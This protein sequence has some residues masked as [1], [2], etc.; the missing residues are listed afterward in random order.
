MVREHATN[1]SQHLQENDWAL[2]HVAAVHARARPDSHMRAPAQADTHWETMV[3][4]A[5]VHSKQ[6]W[7]ALNAWS[8]WK[9]RYWGLS[10]GLSVTFLVFVVLQVW[11]QGCFGRAVRAT[12]ERV[13]AQRTLAVERLVRQ[14]EPFSWVVTAFLRWHGQGDGNA[15][16][17]T[18][19]TKLGWLAELRQAVER[20]REAEALPADPFD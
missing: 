20:L 17:G 2:A 16:R 8:R 9:R 12:T 10:G 3:S 7:L 19:E 18:T 11:N 13:C 6:S 15:T 14:G 1:K 4:R 5:T